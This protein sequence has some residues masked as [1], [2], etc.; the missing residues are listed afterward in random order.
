MV[1][2]KKCLLAIWLP[3]TF[4]TLGPAWADE[5]TLAV[6]GG[7]RRPLTELVTLF[8]ASSDDRVS[9]IYGHIGQIIAQARESDEIAMLCGD[10]AAFD[11]AEGI[12]F[13]EEVPLGLGRLVIA[14][15]TG[16]T[17][18]AAE[19]VA[20][21]EVERIGVPDQKMAIYG[22]AATQYL[23]RSGLM[24]TVAPRIMPVGS[25]PQVTRYVGAGEVDAGFV[26][27]TDAI[28][29]G[30]EIG[31]Y[32]EVDPALYDPVEAVCVRRAGAQSEALDAFTAFLRG[33]EARAVLARHGL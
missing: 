33:D 23:E 18:D 3:A 11:A 2:M 21:P 4:A 13:S 7:F 32:V 20:G 31:G 12:T 26:N 6:V 24:E 8:E 25:V 1:Q 27:A 9:R 30:D 10:K 5:T 14:Y 22:R 28:G 17:L 16:L 15:R 19:D 29:A